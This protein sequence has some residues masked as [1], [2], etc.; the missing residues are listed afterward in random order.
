MME[1]Q[2]LNPDMIDLHV[3]K[4]STKTRPDRFRK[5]HSVGT[6]IALIVLA[7]KIMFA[8]NN[9]EIVQWVL[10][11]LRPL[12]LQTMIFCLISYT[13][14]VSEALLMTGLEVKNKNNSLLDSMDLYQIK[15]LLNGSTWVHIG[16]ITLFTVHQ[17]YAQCII[18]TLSI[19][20]CRWHKC[21]CHWQ[22]SIESSGIY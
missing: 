3:G 15:L 22:E 12:I 2:R 10:L 16:T 13:R 18:C 7:E 21:I 17:W 11:S 4:T 20:V 9:G 8:F 1:N 14:M 6:D 5:G 19:A